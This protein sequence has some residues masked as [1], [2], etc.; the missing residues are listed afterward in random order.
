MSRSSFLFCTSIFISREHW[1]RN[2]LT[3][4]NAWSY[5]YIYIFLYLFVRWLTPLS[6]AWYCLYFYIVAGYFQLKFTQALDTTQNNSRA[7]VSRAKYCFSPDSTFFIN[8]RWGC[9]NISA[10]VGTGYKGSDGCN[11]VLLQEVI[12]WD[13]KVGI[14]TEMHFL[15]Y[16]NYPFWGR[17]SC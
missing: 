16:T 10:G 17:A 11:I 15:I 13:C 1:S 14:E 12:C 8:Y 7:P 2:N 5:I 6:E 4:Y 3:T 9:W